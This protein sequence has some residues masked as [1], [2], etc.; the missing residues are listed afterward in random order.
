MKKLRTFFILIFI[1]SQIVTGDAQEIRYVRQQLDILCSPDSHGRGYYKRG[2]RITA[3]HLAAEYNEFD[4]RSYG[5]DY[6]QDYSFNINSLE[7]V[8]VKIN[9]NE[10]LFGDDCMMKASSG[11]G[12]GKFKPV[13]INAELILKP[14][15]LFTALDDAGKMPSF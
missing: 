3:E 9:G 12:R 15:D 14:E 7:N 11:S 5:E 13:I 4:L 10:L 2:D 1:F 8:S 6:F